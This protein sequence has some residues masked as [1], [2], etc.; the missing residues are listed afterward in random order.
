MGTSGSWMTD[1]SFKEAPTRPCFVFSFEDLRKD[2]VM[3]N[4]EMVPL[5]LVI[6]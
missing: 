4:E 6:Y 5:K 2:G 3:N 1:L